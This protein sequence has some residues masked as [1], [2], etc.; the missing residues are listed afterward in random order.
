M[1]WIRTSGCSSPSLT[2]EMVVSQPTIT[3]TIGTRRLEMVKSTCP[4]EVR[5]MG[6]TAGFK[7][8]TSFL[9]SSNCP[10]SNDHFNCII[11]FKNP[12]LLFPTRRIKLAYIKP[13]CCMQDLRSGIWPKFRASRVKLHY[14][15]PFTSMTTESVLASW[16]YIWM[17]Y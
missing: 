7:K 5:M 2:E 9:L 14:R 6:R 12:I 17:S 8:L 1:C 16:L 15:E 10:T 13:K 4:L 11:Y 3:V